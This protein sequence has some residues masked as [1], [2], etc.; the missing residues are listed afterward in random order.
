METLGQELNGGLS[1][2]WDV[3]CLYWKDSDGRGIDSFGDS[4]VWCL[5]WL[6]DQLSWEYLHMTSPH[7][8]CFSQ[9]GIWLLRQGSRDEPS[10]STS[11]DLVG[12][13]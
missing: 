3:W 1:L 5:G 2:L 13:L 7:G 6:K 4:Y 9:R 8:L 11:W 12:L 10:K